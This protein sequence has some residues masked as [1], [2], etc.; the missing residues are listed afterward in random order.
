MEYKK[1]TGIL[2]DLGLSQNE[3][4]VYCAALS[5]GPTTILNIAH[6]SNVKRTS[7]YSIIESLKEKGLMLIEIKGFKKLFVAAN[8]DHL[9]ETIEAR[10]ARLKDAL[11]E[12]SALYNLKGGESFIKYYEGLTGIKSVYENLIRDVRPHEDYL[13]IT[14][15]KRWFDLDRKY[16]LDF[17]ERRAKLPINIRMLMQ[18]SDIAR[19]FKK[20]EKNYNAHIKLLP[21]NTT[22]IT[23]LVVI[24]RRVVIHQLTPPILAIIIENKSVVQMHRELFEIIWKSLPE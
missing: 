5:L 22:L 16:F 9:E 18:D 20:K 1:I 14:D 21:K 11:P 3:A 24:P 6:A 19:D 23:N 7:I 4:S 15:Q 13:V 8:P 10:R 12:L 2:T 17:T